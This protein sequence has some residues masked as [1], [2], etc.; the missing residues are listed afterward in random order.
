M[1]RYTD[2]S[3][4]C[5]ASSSILLAIALNFSFLLITTVVLVVLLLFVFFFFF[6]SASAASQQLIS[7]CA[8]RAALAHWRPQRTRTAIHTLIESL[9][10]SRSLAKSSERFAYVLLLKCGKTTFLHFADASGCWLRLLRRRR[11]CQVS[12]CFGDYTMVDNSTVVRYGS[13]RN[14]VRQGTARW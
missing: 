10:I 7:G 6:F 12:I 8:T 2:S 9:K 13:C 1:S 11:S 3:S 14:F 4:T 5:G